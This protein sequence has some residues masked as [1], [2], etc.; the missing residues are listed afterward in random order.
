MPEK[1][2]GQVQTEVQTTPDVTLGQVENRSPGTVT[3]LQE[4]VA[5]LRDA[6][7]L[8]KASQESTVALLEEI[9]SLSANMSEVVKA[10]GAEDRAAAQADAELEANEYLAYAKL[11]SDRATRE[12]LLSKAVQRI[13]E[14]R[15]DAFLQGGFRRALNTTP[16]AR[17]QGAEAAHT[18]RQLHRAND[19]I[20]S[21]MAARAGVIVSEAPQGDASGAGRVTINVDAATRLLNN[22]LD[23]V[24]RGILGSE[25]GKVASHMLSELRDGATSTGVGS[26]AELLPRPLSSSYVD[27]VYD[28]LAVAGLFPR[29]TMTTRTQKIP[30]IRGGANVYRT[31]ESAAVA[32]LFQTVVADSNIPTGEITFEAESFAA[33][34]LASWEFEEDNIL[35]WG[36]IQLEKLRRATG[37]SIENAIINGSTL[38]NDLDNAGADGSRWWANT[39]ASGIQLATGALDPRNAVDGLRKRARAKSYTLD[40]GNNAANILKGIKNLH[41]RGQSNFGGQRNR[42]VCAMPFVMEAIAT[43]SDPN[44][45]TLDKFGPNATVLTGQIG[46]AYGIPLV[47]SDQIPT[48]LN[49]SGVYDGV[50]TNRTEAI[51]FHR[52][53][54][55]IGTRIDPEVYRGG[56]TLGLVNYMFTRLRWDFQ[57][58][59]TNS[60]KTVGTLYNIPTVVAL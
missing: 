54:F 50:T 14:D 39:T 34:T 58:M 17:V 57:E 22:V 18:L 47:V 24:N 49:A 25:Y 15:A 26:G 45:M 46:A 21:W 41:A 10:I 29:I 43:F 55:A 59:Y 8:N 1:E 11:T 28:Q 33:L 60:D 7:T 35:N 9:R 16:S 30:A 3:A 48:F 4:T 12:A 56:A 37:E 40:G 13:G 5:A 51:L 31:T 6:A 32:R 42:W 44:F 36:D 52:D 27:E 53:A 19:V 23:Q 38:L 2:N 20:V